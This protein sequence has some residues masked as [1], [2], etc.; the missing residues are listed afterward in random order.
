MILVA[1][2]SVIVFLKVIVFF[3]FV[4]NYKSVAP[5]ADDDQLPTVSVLVPARDE[6]GNIAQCLDALLALDY[7]SHKLEILVGN[8]QSQ[9]KTADIANEYAGRYTYIKVL[10]ISPDYH[11]L[12]ARSNVLAQLAVASDHELLVFLDADLEVTKGW[13]RQMV[14]PTIQGFDLVSGLTE[15]KPTNWLARYQQVDWLNVIMLLKVGADLGQPGTA[16]GNNMLVTREAYLAVG[17]YEA[18]GPTFTED[19]DLTLALRSKG[20]K[21]S[22]VM[23]GDKALTAPVD[24]Y[25]ELLKQRNRWMQ[26]AF[27]QPLG[28]LLPLLVSR[29]FV[30]WILLLFIWDASASVAALFIVCFWEMVLSYQMAAK[31]QTTIPLI[32]A[33]TAPVFN[34]V[35]DTFTLLSYPRNRRVEWKGRK[36]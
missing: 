15:V 24:T 13:L 7:P 26:G 33:F 34:S 16:L 12:V 25:K 23:G 17:G 19:N 14:A 28:S 3:A 31:T 32:Y 9:D 6:E 4:L 21:L 18:N 5:V 10:D 11:E 1:L 8:D 22:Q 29:I 36:L 2:I 30:L 20:Y 27:R 35:L